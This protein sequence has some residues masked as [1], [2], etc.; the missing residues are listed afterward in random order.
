MCVTLASI[1]RLLAKAPRWVRV[2]ASCDWN[3]DPMDCAKMDT[4]GVDVEGQSMPWQL[5]VAAAENLVSRVA[6]MSAK[7]LLCRCRA[8]CSMQTSSSTYA[9]NRYS[10]EYRG[11]I[12]HVM[13]L[14]SV[15][16]FSHQI[17]RL[18]GGWIGSTSQPTM[19]GHASR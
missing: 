13:H 14:S 6:W 2:V 12:K 3:V 5:E 10:P 19:I 8:P 17:Y 18:S 7:T 9:P 4:G 11:G 1:N 16:R 15:G